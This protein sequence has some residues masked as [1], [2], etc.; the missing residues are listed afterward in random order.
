MHPDELMAL[1][2]VFVI[3]PIVMFLIATSPRWL[4]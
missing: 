4:P 2:W 3:G 1:F